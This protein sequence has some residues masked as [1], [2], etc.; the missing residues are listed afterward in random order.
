MY[1]S[2]I[3][4]KSYK[5]FSDSGDIFFKPGINVIIGPNNSGKTAL[6]EAINLR[7]ILNPHKRADNRDNQQPSTIDFSLTINKEELRHSPFTTMTV[8]TPS[9]GRTIGR[10]IQ[11]FLWGSFLYKDHALG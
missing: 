1:L 5:S 6:L 7:S 3:R 9:N 10:F 11:T 4:I 8:P 2:R